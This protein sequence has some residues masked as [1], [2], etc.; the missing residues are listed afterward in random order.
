MIQGKPG[1]AIKVSC[2]VKTVFGMQPTEAQALVLN[3]KVTGWYYT[4]SGEEVP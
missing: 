2:N 1:W 4:G 3:G